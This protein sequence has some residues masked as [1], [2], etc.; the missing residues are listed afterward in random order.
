MRKFKIQ[1]V[2]CKIIVFLIF[3][4]LILNLTFLDKAFA[5][6]TVDVQPNH[7]GIGF[8]Y[9]GGKVNVSGITS[10][11]TDIIMTITSPE[12]YQTLKRKGKVGGLF[13]MNTGT[14]N[15]E[16][17]SSLYILTSTK[18]IKDILS[19]EEINKYLIGYEALENHI[20][21]SPVSNEQ[22]KM[23]WWLEFVKFHE[24]SKLYEISHGRITLK[25]GTAGIPA[26]G[27][28][29]KAKQTYCISSNW[30]YQAVPD[31]YTVTVYATRDGKIVEKAE[32]NVFVEQVGIIKFLANM[33][34]DKGALYGI[35]SIV[36]ALSVG[37]S[38]G[39]IFRKGGAH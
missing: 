13:W 15:F 16:K 5:E 35:I 24:A 39:M 21:I 14:L 29:V 32:K 17:V 36:V 38:V 34:K 6:L 3:A 25:Q 23:K 27:E 7:I 11:D 26:G 9:H 12:G 30:P 28:G 18:K 4:I 20:D 2:K 1:N 10:P 22:E 33:A 37:F 19:K 31:T 8:F